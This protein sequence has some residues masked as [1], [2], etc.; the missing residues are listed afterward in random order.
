MALK[1]FHF[2]VY[3]SIKSL[4]IYLPNLKA[5]I[6]PKTAPKKT[7]KVPKYIFK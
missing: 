7:D 4:N 3:F 6:L 2:F 1:Y 5:H